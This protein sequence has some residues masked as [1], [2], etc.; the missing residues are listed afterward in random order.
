[1]FHS[2]Q[3][4]VASV[5]REVFPAVHQDLW[6]LKLKHLINLKPKDAQIRGASSEAC[7]F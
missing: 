3:V 7:V 2:A 6:F 4:A 1:M 5:L